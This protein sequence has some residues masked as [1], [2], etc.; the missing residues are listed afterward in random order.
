MN[1]T[2]R[3]RPLFLQDLTAYYLSLHD[4]FSSVG[5]FPASKMTLHMLI[6]IASG[7]PEV[8]LQHEQTPLYHSFKTKLKELI[9]QTYRSFVTGALNTLP[10]AQKAFYDDGAPKAA[11]YCPTK[12]NEPI[13]QW[14]FYPRFISK[15]DFI[16]PH[17]FYQAFFAYKELSAWVEIVDA[18]FR[19]ATT[20]DEL[21]LL[22]IH[23]ENPV[24]L[25]LYFQRL[26]ETSHIVYIRHGLGY[27]TLNSNR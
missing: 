6:L 2:K 17:S 22:S 20:T 8:L 15:K 3:L 19:S 13:D 11:F 1:Q 26:I 14:D 21:N 7:P 23:N 4:F 10:A 16:T 12:L 24:L 25:Y 18:L 27:A 9:E 5:G